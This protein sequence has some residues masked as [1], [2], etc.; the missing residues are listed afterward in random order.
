MPISYVGMR[1]E[2]TTWWEPRQSTSRLPDGTTSRGRRIGDSMKYDLTKKSVYMY[3]ENPDRAVPHRVCLAP[4]RVMFDNDIN[5]LLTASC[6]RLSQYKYQSQLAYLRT[7]KKFALF[8]REQGR[9]TLPVTEWQWQELIVECYAWHLGGKLGGRLAT[10]QK[11]WR[12]SFQKWFRMMQEEGVIP[13]SVRIPRARLR[14]EVS[15]H[16]SVKAP[17]NL[18]EHSPENSANR[19][20]GRNK[21]LAGDLWASSD[22]EYLRAIEETL[23]HRVAVLRNVVDDYW[24]RLVRD[25]RTGKNAMRK[26]SRDDFMSCVRTGDWYSAIRPAG[27][28]RPYLRTNPAVQDSEAWALCIMRHVLQTSNSR[29]CLKGATLARHPGLYAFF[30]LGA[31]FTPLDVLRKKSALRPEQIRRYT[32]P[33][34][35]QRFLGVLNQVDIAVACVILIQEHPNLNPKSVLSARLLD[36]NG[37]SLLLDSGR[38]TELVFSVDKPRANARKYAELTPRAARVMRHIVRVTQDVRALLKR[39]GSPLWRHLFVGNGGRFLGHPD[40]EAK[41]LTSTK[42]PSLIRYYPELAEAGLESGS[43]DFAKVRVTHGILDW[44]RTGSIRTV[45]RKLG[46]TVRVALQHYIP[47]ELIHLWN[48]RVLRRFQNTLI[49][50]AAGA[51]PRMLCLSDLKNGEAL[52]DFLRDIA[53]EFPR[54]TSPIGPYVQLL[55]KG[56]GRSLNDL[57]KV[58]SKALLTIQLDPYSLALLYA[59]SEVQERQN[60]HAETEV[61][62]WS[63]SISAEQIALLGRFLRAAAES[64]AVGDAISESLQ[65][66]KLRRM[67]HLALPLVPTL[68]PFLSDSGKRGTEGREL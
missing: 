30:L 23:H 20:R 54:A 53:L 41:Q 5:E 58:V 16:G 15:R 42:L 57:E 2:L 37:N 43:L 3:L 9:I 46:N 26:V 68:L 1:N 6:K 67:H 14:L 59:F 56:E 48:E 29:D 25:Y 45:S 8:L 52:T 4:L 33:M 49:L 35:Y 50:L 10:R 27:A 11:Q 47:E 65:V 40:V 64:T 17:R 28:S 12:D 7:I 24:S 39:S 34:F 44:F 18:G 61:F 36:E 55:A 19:R 21:T 32:L 60:G 63:D 62:A 66:V 31:S 51:A 38:G 22:T 13:A